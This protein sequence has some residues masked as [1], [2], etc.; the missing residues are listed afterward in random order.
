M[1]GFERISGSDR[2]FDDT[3]ISSLALVVGDC[4]AYDRT[5]FVAIKAT[6]T[7]SMEDVLGITAEATTTSDTKVKYQK[8]IDKDKFKVG[9]ANNSNA[10]HRFHRMVLTDENTVNNTGTDSTSDAAI[11]MQV[12]TLGAVGDKEIIIEFVTRQDRA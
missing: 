7:T 3:T 5:N 2:G 4:L 1:A 10:E 8:I 9:S 6:S 12:D 11:I